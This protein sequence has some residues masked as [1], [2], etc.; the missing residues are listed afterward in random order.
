MATPAISPALAAAALPALAAYELRL[1]PARR[2]LLAVLEGTDRPL[3]ADEVTRGAELPV[4]TAYR[5]L[6]ELADAGVVV[7]ITAIGG[8]DRYELAEQVSPHHRHHHHLVC[9]RC[10]IVTDFAPSAQLERL[11][12][13]EVQSLLDSTGFEVTNHVFDVRGWCRD[14]RAAE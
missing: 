10:G 9:E 13:K 1:T 11:I 14:C 5:N 8:G 4:S 2:A 3:T 12:A 7:R 6:G